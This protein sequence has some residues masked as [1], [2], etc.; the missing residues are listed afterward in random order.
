MLALGFP[1]L[2]QFDQMSSSRS[3]AAR[4]PARGRVA[5]WHRNLLPDEPS[6]R[7]SRGDATGRFHVEKLFSHRSASA[8]VSAASMAEPYPN[9]RVAIAARR[10]PGWVGD[11]TAFRIA[12]KSDAV[13]PCMTSPSSRTT[14]GTRRAHR[15]SWTSLASRLVRVSTATCDGLTR[16]SPAP[17]VRS[18]RST[19]AVAVQA[20]ARARRGWARVQSSVSASGITQVTSRPC[21]SSGR[22]RSSSRRAAVAA[23]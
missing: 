13:L 9:N 5:G 14:L 17:I 11:R 20:A 10:H 7:R 15:A 23:G 3:G 12:A 8:V 16:V 19:M 2:Q 1:G 21:P 6:A 18:S 22:G 4:R